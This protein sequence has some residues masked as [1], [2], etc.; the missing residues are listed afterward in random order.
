MFL[1]M[2]SSS[3]WY[4][5]C[6]TLHQRS[7]NQRIAGQCS[8]YRRSS[9]LLVHIRTSF[10][11]QW[12]GHF[13]LRY[14]VKSCGNSTQ[15]SRISLV[16]ECYISALRNTVLIPVMASSSVRLPLGLFRSLLFEYGCGLINSLT[17]D[18][19]FPTSSSMYQSGRKQIHR[20]MHYRGLKIGVSC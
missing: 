17:I 20:M 12:E 10:N 16:E 6:Y 11:V 13:T 8:C 4:K 7:L 15:E 14:I 5:V 9:K 3:R 1:R 19:D 2:L 18:F